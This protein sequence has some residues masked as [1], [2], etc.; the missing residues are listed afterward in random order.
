VYQK[1][2]GVSELETFLQSFGGEGEEGV[3]TLDYRAAFERLRQYQLGSTYSPLNCLV[4]SA[5]AAGACTARFVQDE[6]T[7]THTFSHD[8]DS[9]KPEELNHLFTHLLGDDESLRYL[10]I[11]LNC[12]LHGDWSQSTVWTP[13]GRFEFRVSG[14]TFDEESA[15]GFRAQMGGYFG[16]G[17]YRTL[18]QN[19]R[20]APLALY[21]DDKLLNN[22]SAE[23]DKP[24][25]AT[26]KLYNPG[27]DGDHFAVALDYGRGRRWTQL[28]SRAENDEPISTAHVQLTENDDVLH[29]DAVINFT[30]NPKVTSKLHIFRHGLEI[31]QMP[32]DR[33]SG[34]VAFLSSEHLQVDLTSHQ[35]V[36]NEAYYNLLDWVEEQAEELDRLLR[37]AYPTLDSAS[38]LK[39]ARF[40]Y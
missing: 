20:F 24:L 17:V 26:L 29:C 30:E 38:R 34:L 28:S 14:V 31:C 21:Y 6:K 36:M 19:A 39:A 33:R 2:P 40:R 12:S 10:A 13:V 35:V 23:G 27:P 32:F 16:D 15:E 9:P 3:F 18:G 5:V 11:A 25:A 4:M 8:G 7:T 22:P 37:K 1:K